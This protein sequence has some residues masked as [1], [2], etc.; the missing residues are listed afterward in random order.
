MKDKEEI[1][2]EYKDIEISYDMTEED[3]EK[4]IAEVEEENNGK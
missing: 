2:E 4:V 1:L 3:M